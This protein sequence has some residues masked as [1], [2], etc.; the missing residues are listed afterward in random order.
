MKGVVTPKRLLVFYQRSYRFLVIFNHIP[1]VS[2]YLE[3]AFIA[4]CLK[5]VQ[6]VV[7]PQTNEFLSCEIQSH[8]QLSIVLFDGCV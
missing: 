6:L 3:R 7:E 8:K 2:D 1:Y 5:D 4:G